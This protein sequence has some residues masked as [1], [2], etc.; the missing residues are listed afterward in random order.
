VGEKK[1]KFR[2]GRRFEEAEFAVPAVAAPAPSSVTPP[3]PV[4][5]VPMSE[6][7]SP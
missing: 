3:A 2:P 6:L 1:S 4:W 7:L 5:G